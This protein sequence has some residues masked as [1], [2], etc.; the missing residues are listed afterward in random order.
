MTGEAVIT[1]RGARGLRFLL[2]IV[3]CFLLPAPS[4]AFTNYV[5]QGSAMPT[6]PYNTWATAAHNIQ[7]AANAAIEGNVVLVTNGVY[8]PTSQILIATNNIVLKSLNGAENTVVFNYCC[9]TPT[10]NLPGG[11]RCIPDN[12]MF[13]VP[14]DDYHI[15]DGLP[16]IDTGF[17]MV[18]MNSP[19]TELDDDERIYDGIVDIGC[20]EFIPE[21][22]GLSLIMCR[23]SC[24]KYKFKLR[25]R[26]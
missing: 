18:W 16:C 5:W 23:L 22:C 12:P 4:F 13:A 24:V 11:H 8:T 6:P 21:P 10:T 9:T 2:F 1:L 19:A 14:G 3:S 15:S 17:N 25:L 26:L 7:D 20:Y